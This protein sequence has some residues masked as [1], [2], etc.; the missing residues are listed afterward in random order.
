[1][2]QPTALQDAVTEAGASRPTRASARM[3]MTAPGVKQVT[4]CQSINDLHPSC[5]TTPFLS[6]LASF[7][8]TSFLPLRL[9]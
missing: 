5:Q 7:L 3:A 6:R 1:M 8:S 9:S 4:S 2:L